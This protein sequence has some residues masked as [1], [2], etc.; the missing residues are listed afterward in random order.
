[1]Q[2]MRIHMQIKPPRQRTA[3]HITRDH[4]HPPGITTLR[5]QLTS[6]P[7]HRRTLQNRRTQPGPAID[8]STRIHPRIATDVQRP[9]DIPQPVQ[10]RSELPRQKLTTRIHGRHHT[11]RPTR[12]NQPV[13]PV[14]AITRRTRPRSSLPRTQSSQ[15][16]HTTRTLTQRTEIRPHIPPRTRNQILRSQRSQPHLPTRT[17]L[18]Q[19]HS[20]NISDQH[21]KRPG[22]KPELLPH[23]HHTHPTPPTDPRKKIKL[24]NRHNKQ[25]S[26]VNTLPKAEQRHR[27]NQRPP[28]AP[29]T[30]DIHLAHPVPDLRNHHRKG[31]EET[32]KSLPTPIPHRQEHHNPKHQT[33]TTT[34]NHPAT[35]H[36]HQE[37]PAA[38]RHYRPVD[39]VRNDSS[40]RKSA[41]RVSPSASWTR[42]PARCDAVA[43]SEMFN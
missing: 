17:T 13:R 31:Y 37:Q 33:T 22:I 43:R 3:E 20:H 23:L 11:A 14:P 32:T 10:S 34:H 38:T 27:I 35:A 5:Q 39:P 24:R 8:Q 41:R 30:T 21:I 40:G 28:T 9:P 18:H 42:P 7:I 36:S 29:H 26:G 15:H 6:H 19:P 16:L 12:I 4:I 1:M 25:I 2:N